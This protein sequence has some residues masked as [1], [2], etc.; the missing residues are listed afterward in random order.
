M[1]IHDTGKVQIEKSLVAATKH[2]V[3]EFHA[4]H[5][6]CAQHHSLLTVEFVVHH[7]IDNTDESLVCEVVHTLKDFF[8]KEF[9][10]LR[11]AQMTETLWW[12]HICE[13]FRIIFRDVIQGMMFLYLRTDF[14]CHDLSFNIFVTKS[15]NGRILPS[16]IQNTIGRKECVNQITQLKDAMRTVIAFPFNGVIKNLELPL[17]LRRFLDFDHS[18]CFGPTWFVINCPFFWTVNKKVQFAHELK[19]LFKLNRNIKWEIETCLKKARV[20]E[21]WKDKVPEGV[22]KKILHYH[23]STTSKAKAEVEDKDKAK[24]GDGSEAEVEDKAGDGSACKEVQAFD[25]YHERADIC[26]FFV[27]SYMHVNDYMYLN[28]RRFKPLRRA[29]IEAALS[30]YFPFFYVDM[31]ECLCKRA[32]ELGDE[33]LKVVSSLGNASDFPP[34]KM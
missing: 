12:D 14:G 21:F 32:G 11:G 6:I 22:Y 3:K 28:D 15:G 17:E 13:S 4:L 30:T 23:E 10:K 26:R 5:S 29:E 8:D 2:Q 31:F 20:F 19:M 9:Q 1:G 7:P 16:M 34:L 25:G 27:A 18:R 24:V 33:V